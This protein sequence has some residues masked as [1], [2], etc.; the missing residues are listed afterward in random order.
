MNKKINTFYGNVKIISFRSFLDMVPVKILDGSQSLITFNTHVGIPSSD[1]LEWAYKRTAL[2]LTEPSEQVLKGHLL[3]QA[4]IATSWMKPPLELLEG[5]VT[6]YL[7]SFGV[8]EYVIR[9]DRRFWL[10]ANPN[11][12]CY[13]KSHR[14]VALA[15]YSQVRNKVYSVEKFTQLR[16]DQAVKDIKAKT[17]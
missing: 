11:D 1:E 8:P 13:I 10:I 17:Y 16:Y 7:M 9:L 5:A 15:C 6:D 14:G 4:E 2:L 12:F 3:S